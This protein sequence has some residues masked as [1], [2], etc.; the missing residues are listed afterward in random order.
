MELR[1]LRTWGQSESLLA[2]I[3]STA[4]LVSRGEVVG[5]LHRLPW[6]RTNVCLY[7]KNVEL[8]SDYYGVGFVQIDEAG[9]W[10]PELA[11]E[12]KAAGLNVDM[13]KAF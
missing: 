8:P 9:A 10:K 4:S 3:R 6:T 2:D 11:R 12:M 5:V 1:N 13:N 7:A